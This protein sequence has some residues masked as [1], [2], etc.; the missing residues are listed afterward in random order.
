MALDDSCTFD[1]E[2]YSALGEALFLNEPV[3]TSLR[4]LWEHCRTCRSCL[5]KV[6][7]ERLLCVPMRAALVRQQRE[8]AVVLTIILAAAQCQVRRAEAHWLA[9]QARVAGLAGSSR[10]EDGKSGGIVEY[11]GELA[12]RI[13]N[14]DS[15]IEITVLSQ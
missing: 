15:V 5:A 8:R 2:A 3:P 7:E 6:E 11:D 14:L 12:V 13:E 1:E 4:E 9:Q 10:A